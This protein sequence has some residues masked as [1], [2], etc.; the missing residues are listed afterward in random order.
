M[1]HFAA[2]AAV[3]RGRRAL[4]WAKA[5]ASAD[6]CAAATTA[7]VQWHWIALGPHY[8][9]QPWHDQQDSQ[10]DDAC[11]HQL[12]PRVLRAGGHSSCVV[13]MLAARMCVLSVWTTASLSQ[14]SASRICCRCERLLPHNDT[15]SPCLQALV[16]A[17]LDLP[18]MMAIAGV[19]CSST[20]LRVSPV[21]GF[22]MAW[23]V[24]RI[25]S[26]S[27]AAVKPWTSKLMSAGV[28]NSFATAC[29]SVQVSN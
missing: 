27:M 16:T 28:C 20:V 23:Q 19:P 7:P 6:D 2:S 11:G 24:P 17:L 13:S 5:D 15:C 12:S 10:C 9:S 8:E 18:A 3:W 21:P 1:W 22:T 14:D 29:P 26:C 4:Q 25:C